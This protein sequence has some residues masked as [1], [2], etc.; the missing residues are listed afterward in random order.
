[1][2]S[3]VTGKLLNPNAQGLV[4]KSFRVSKAQPASR[5][6]YGTA[7]TFSTN[8]SG[9]FSFTLVQGFY[10]LICGNDKIYFRV[11]DDGVTYN[12]GDIVEPLK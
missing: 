1:M 2:A 5:I 12:F 8:S 10:I 3:T 4:N 7:M 9:V 6:P 11:K